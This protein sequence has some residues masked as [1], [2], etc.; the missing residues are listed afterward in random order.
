M[1]G[2]GGAVGRLT[3]LSKLL[4]AHIKNLGL[5]ISSFL[6]HPVFNSLANASGLAYCVQ[7]L[8]TFHYLQY[9]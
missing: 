7:N 1:V 9:Y 5:I 6:F 8:I 3:A 2:V 4:V